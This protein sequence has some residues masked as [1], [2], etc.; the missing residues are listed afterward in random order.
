MHNL[1]GI[2]WIHFI[3]GILLVVF[4]CWVLGLA[5]WAG[6]ATAGVNK[7]QHFH[8]GMLLL[9]LGVVGGT[10]LPVGVVHGIAGWK[11]LK[12]SIWM[13]RVLQVLV[14]GEVLGVMPFVGGGQTGY[15]LFPFVLGL[16][17]YTTWAL[18]VGNKE[19]AKF[20]SSSKLPS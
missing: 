17:G 13:G 12:G 1:K 16:A 3:L 19:E 7:P 5:W 14:W 9:A 11:L 18:Q 15:M 2:A 4:A 6:H 20:D 8:E 10:L